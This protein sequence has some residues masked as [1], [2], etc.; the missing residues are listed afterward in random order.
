MCVYY[1]MCACRCT[2]VVAAHSPASPTP[3]PFARLI[4]CRYWPVCGWLVNWL[5]G[6][7]GSWQIVLIIT[8]DCTC[9]TAGEGC[10]HIGQRC[11]SHT[12]T[13]THTLTH[14]HHMHRITPLPNPKAAYYTHLHV[15]APHEASGFRVC[16]QGGARMGC[17][18]VNDRAAHHHHHF[19]CS[20]LGCRP[21]EW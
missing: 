5:V 4:T 16:R 18:G 7:I 10:R 20:C 9:M 13:H 21:G 2:S 17:G 19:C 15:Q 14:T 1:G 12:H 6:W 8:C 3:V 11:R